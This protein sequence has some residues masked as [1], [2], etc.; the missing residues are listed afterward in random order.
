MKHF[1]ELLLNKNIFKSQDQGPFIKGKRG[2]E[3]KTA[4][5]IKLIKKSSQIV[6]KVLSEIIDLIQPGMSTKDLDIFAEKRIREMG[7]TPSF[8]G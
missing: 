3:I 7:A 2:I 4:R 1:A 6:S 5:E 8:K